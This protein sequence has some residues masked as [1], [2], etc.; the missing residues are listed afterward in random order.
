VTFK[1]LPA[2]TLHFVDDVRPAKDYVPFVHGYEPP[3][4][5][6]Q[7]HWLFVPDGVRT[8][9]VVGASEGVAGARALELLSGAQRLSARDEVKTALERPLLSALWFSMAGWS[10]QQQE[11]DAKS[12]RDRARHR[13]EL[14]AG[15]A[16]G[17]AA[18]MLVTLELQRDAAAGGFAVRARSALDVAALTDVLTWKS[19]P[20]LTGFD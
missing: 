19:M 6:Y 20:T 9:I 13:L 7:R 4:L 16:N 5:P 1:G 15:A 10:L 11:W 17:A 8:W 14:L 12:Q 3:V 18:P 2:T